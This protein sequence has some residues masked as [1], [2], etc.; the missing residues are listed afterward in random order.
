M[1]STFTFE[2]RKS[3]IDLMDSNRAG[4]GE[5]NEG[6]RRQAWHEIITR[7]WL[8]Y[9]RHK[10]QSKTQ[11]VRHCRHLVSTYAAEPPGKMEHFASRGKSYVN[12][13][14][15]SAVV[16]ATALLK[17]PRTR[18]Q[19]SDNS[20][21]AVTPDDV[22]PVHH[23]S[24]SERPQSR[25]SAIQDIDSAER[26]INSAEQGSHWALQA[27][28]SSLKASRNTQQPINRNSEDIK[29]SRLA[30][31][32]MQS[33][34]DPYF[35]DDNEV[36]G[37]L[38]IILEKA[39]HLAGT[40]SKFLYCNKMNNTAFQ[41]AGFDEQ[42]HVGTYPRMLAAICQLLFDRVFGKKPDYYNDEALGQDLATCF[43]QD[44]KLA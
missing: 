31:P 25:D 12:P 23:A 22:Q 9:P 13:P 11:I 42:L 30:T 4:I 15:G 33:V 1:C 44:G 19:T 17:N 39:H 40:Y 20:S 35:L 29:V 5:K 28:N 6:K 2:E 16:T 37:K 7:L 41:L 21:V 26:D 27:S 3:L 24:L 32:S 14:L 8:A 38:L 10:E 34:S 18:A 36:K 43:R